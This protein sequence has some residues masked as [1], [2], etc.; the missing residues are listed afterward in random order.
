M[1]K[2]DDLTDLIEE[3][4]DLTSPNH[5]LQMMRKTIAFIGAGITCSILSFAGVFIFNESD[6]PG[7]KNLLTSPQNIFSPPESVLRTR[8]DPGQTNNDDRADQKE[9]QP[10]N[11]SNT[12]SLSKENEHHRPIAFDIPPSDHT[13]QTQPTSPLDPKEYADLDQWLA[14]LLH[15]SNQAAWTMSTNE[16]DQLFLSGFTL[17]PTG[18]IKGLSD[19]ISL[20]LPLISRKNVAIYPTFANVF[21]PQHIS[22][23]DKRKKTVKMLL[24]F[25]HS[26]QLDGINLQ[27]TSVS[28]KDS[29]HL[30]AFLEELSH[31]FHRQGKKVNITVFADHK[32]EN[33]SRLAKACDQFHLIALHTDGKKPGSTIPL[34]WLDQ[35]ISRAKRQVPASKIVIDLPTTGYLWSSKQQQSITSEQVDMLIKKS[36]RSVRRDKNNEPYL[37][38]QTKEDTYVIYYQDEKSL[39]NKVEWIRQNHPDLAGVYMYE[40]GNSEIHLRK[41]ID[42][43]FQ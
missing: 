11:E 2:I 15:S 17:E 27:F 4:L 28:A 3:E 20:N 29:N 5:A 30:F 6:T 36:P 12:P 8:D 1:R 42:P 22:S 21:D 31:E 33:W 23:P 25:V 9:E 19:L 14:D 7:S 18:E 40:K 24:R 39:M 13:R 41:I 35:V 37:N 34:K 43:I 10:T 26:H 32:G 16:N 38:I